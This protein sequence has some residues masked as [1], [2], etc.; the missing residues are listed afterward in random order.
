MNLKTLTKYI[1]ELGVLKKIRHSGFVFAG[2]K[3]QDTL[4]E[5]MLRT[6]QIGYFLAKMEKVDPGKV[7]QI[8]IF[9]DNAEVRIGDLNKINQIYIKNKSNIEKKAFQDQIEKFPDQIKKELINFYNSQDKLSSKEGIVARDADLLETMFE[10][11]EKSEQGYDTKRWL[12]NGSKYLKTKSAKKL[13][14]ELVKTKTTSW[15]SNL[16]IVK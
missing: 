5:H 8:C 3:N 4:G 10:A 12:L 2:L 1:N 11:K 9:H 7:V 15:W 16:N 13:F 14:K 6:A